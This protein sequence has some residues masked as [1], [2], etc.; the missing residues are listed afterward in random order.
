MAWKVVVGGQR[1]VDV[2]RRDRR[3]AKRS[4]AA[5]IPARSAAVRSGTA[6]ATASSCIA[7]TTAWASRAARASSVLT[8][9]ERPGAATTR[10]AC[11]SRSNASRTGVRETP[12][13]CARSPSRSCSP[14]ANVPSTIAS[15]SRT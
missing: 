9:V 13:H 6:V 4:L 1:R 10:P 8:V 15:R 7:A 11:A 12:S 3:R 2:A 5:R 14:G